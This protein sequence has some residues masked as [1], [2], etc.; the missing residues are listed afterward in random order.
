ETEGGYWYS[1]ELCFR[2]VEG[3]AQ[4]AGIVTT[5]I[6]RFSQEE[7]RPLTATLGVPGLSYVPDRPLRVRVQ[8]VGPHLRMRVW[9]PDR[10]EPAVW[11]SQAWDDTAP[12]GGV[13]GLEANAISG[14]VLPPGGIRVGFGDLSV[15]PSWEVEEPPVVRFT[16]EVPS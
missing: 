8:T 1:F 10:T 9:D 7:T 2:S 6:Q 14:A 3:I 15:A 11:H 5:S 13:V 12:H 4:G 16:G